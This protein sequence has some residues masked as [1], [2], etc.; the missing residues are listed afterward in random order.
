MWRPYWPILDQSGIRLWK[1]QPRLL[2]EPATFALFFLP[3]STST[4]Q[5]PRQ[6]TFCLIRLSVTLK[7][8]WHCSSATMPAA[9]PPITGVCAPSHCS[10][11][12]PIGPIGLPSKPSIHVTDQEF[13]LYRCSAVVWFWTWAPLSVSDWRPSYEW[14]DSWTSGRCPGYSVIAWQNDIGND[15]IEY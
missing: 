4:F 6:V 14:H 11:V 7:I 12:D 2:V 1:L 15:I 9:I 8:D 3:P 10:R 13:D 5:P